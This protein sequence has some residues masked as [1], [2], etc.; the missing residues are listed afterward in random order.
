[1]QTWIQYVEHCNRRFCFNRFSTGDDLQN[2]ANMFSVERAVKNDSTGEWHLARC[3]RGQ[4]VSKAL[5]ACLPGSRYKYHCGTFAHLCQN[6]CKEAGCV[7]RLERGERECRAAFAPLWCRK[8]EYESYCSVACKRRCR[9]QHKALCT[10]FRGIKSELNL[11]DAC[12]HCGSVG[13][14]LKLCGKCKQVRYCSQECLKAGWMGGHK[15]ECKWMASH[16]YE[17]DLYD[18]V[19]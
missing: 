10:S 5:P 6:K 1:M 14:K 18:D 3:K 9:K 2:H 16:D 7:Q 15:E 12:H 19:D 8:C 4:G 13:T 17:E 11:P